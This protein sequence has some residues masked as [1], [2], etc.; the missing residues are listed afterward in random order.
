MCEVP[1]GSGVK[2]ASTLLLPLA[3]SIYK[4][5]LPFFLWWSC[6]AQDDHARSAN[7]RKFSASD[8]APSANHVAREVGSGH[9]K[10]LGR[11]QVA[12][13]H[14][15]RAAVRKEARMQQQQQAANDRGAQKDGSRAQRAPLFLSECL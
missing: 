1:Q 11:E 9:M 6:L 10:P 8:A 4:I 15:A 3:C 7:K 2:H 5:K 14:E 13:E 12:A